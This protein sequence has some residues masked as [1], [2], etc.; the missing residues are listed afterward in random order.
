VKGPSEL[1]Q[2]ILFAHGDILGGGAFTL[3]SLLYLNFLV[4]TQSL[5]PGLAGLL[6]LIGK[7]FDAAIDLFLGYLTDHTRTRFG[8]RRIYFLIGTVPVFVT[9]ILL[10]CDFGIPHLTGK[11]IYFLT[12]YCLFCGASSFV[13]VPYNA[14]FSEI[15]SGYDQRTVYMG[16]RLLFSVSSSILAGVLPMLIVAYSAN[17]RTGYF[18]MGIAFGALY[19]LPWLLVFWGTRENPAAAVPRK[20]RFFRQYA[21]VFKN[22]SFRYYLAMFLFGMAGADLLLS[23]FIYFVTS[24]LKRPG[25]FPIAAGVT[26][27]AQLIGSQVWT[28]VAKKYDKTMSIKIGGLLWAAG[29]FVCFLL[30]PSSPSWFLYGAAILIGIGSIAFNQ[31]PWS[32]L[33]DVVD[34]GELITGKRQEGV[35]SGIVTFL[36]QAANAIAL[37]VSGLL[38]ELA[39]YA[40]AAADG[41]AVMQTVGTIAALRYI[42]V[43]APLV[44]LALAVLAA[45]R[46]PLTRD[47]LTAVKEARRLLKHGKSLDDAAAPDTAMRKKIYAVTGAREDRLWGHAV[48][49]SRQGRSPIS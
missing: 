41:T 42:Y 16:T 14:L 8:R 9:F 23:L 2:R 33:P 26:I 27:I 38:L 45:W 47:R 39:G 36:R 12:V 19:A 21:E 28:R 48:S 4:N 44:F 10:W 24:V 35:Y 40:E 22:R 13:M 31:T 29:L 7:L 49:G 43:L 18:T 15:A 3:L 25:D 32:A 1:R 17:V 34:V 11:F 20:E 5:P 37:G 6:L 46:Y 30:T